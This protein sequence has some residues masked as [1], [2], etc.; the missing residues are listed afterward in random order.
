MNISSSFWLDKRVLITGHTG[1]KGCWL[2]VWLAK[3]GARVTGYSLDFLPPPA[4][5]E[6]FFNGLQSIN[7]FGINHRFGDIRDSVSLGSV[8]AEVEPEI[9]FH[10][11]AQSIVGNSYL[12]PVDTWTTNVIGSLQLL[13]A[14]K[15]RR[16]HC[17]VVLVTTDKVYQ[18]LNWVYGYRETDRLGGHDPYSASKSAMEIAVSSWRSSF[19]GDFPHQ[20]QHLALATA[21]AGNVI[22]GGDWASSRIVPDAIRA[23]SNRVAIHVRNPESTRPWQHVLEP[24]SGYLLLAQNLY[25]SNLEATSS[26]NT[27]ADC[28]N[29]G[30]QSEANRTVRDLVNCILEHWPGHW[31]DTSDPFAPHEAAKLNLVSDKAHHQLGWKPRWDF[32]TTVARTVGWYRAVYNGASA[33]DCCLADLDAYQLDEI[34]AS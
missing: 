29:F 15:D 4:S 24:L 32:A 13:E 1:Y 14:L 30:P 33:L 16:D 5:G 34:H 7:D 11:A 20:T 22:G 10:L 6:G 28:F 8:I 31:V 23:L 12:D 2:S 19:C 9:V 21:R 3:M 26:L 25:L 27:Y 18:N 17:A